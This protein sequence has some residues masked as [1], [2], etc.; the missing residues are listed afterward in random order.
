VEAALLQGD[1]CAALG[2][3]RKAAAAFGRAVDAGSEGPA[4]LRLQGRRAAA[5]MAELTGDARRLGRECRLGL[6]ELAA[7][8]ATVASAEL[9]ARAAGH[10]TV[11]AE[12]GLRAALRSGRPERIWSWLE[13]SRSVV[14]ARSAERPDEHLAPLLAELRS[15]RSRFDELPPDA[16]V[17]RNE[18]LRT[19]TALESRIRARSWTSRSATQRWITP[20]VRALRELR[21]GL[22]ERALL[23]Y[24]E[25][26]GS[27]C[28]VVVT[29]TRIRFAALGRVDEVVGSGRQLGFALRRLSHPR[30]RA[31]V[32]AAFGSANEELRHLAVALLEPL[33]ESFADADEV[34]V[35]PPGDLIGIPW[36]ALEPLADRPVRVVPSALAWWQG[37]DRQPASARAVLVAGPD[38]PAADDEIR[39]IARRYGDAVELSGKRATVEAVQRVAAGARIVHIAGHGRLRSDSPTFSSLQLAD[40]PLTVHDIEGLAEPA[41]HWVLAACDLGNPGAVAGPAL[42][43]VLASLLSGGAGAVVAAVVSVPDLSTRDLMVALHD[44]LAA[45]VAMPESLRRARR[46]L[47]ASDPAGFVAGTAFACYGGG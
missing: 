33:A 10:G 27:L 15:L 5:R 45:G 41:H 14:Y 4:L 25:L 34:I 28:A 6:D 3:T 44:G 12:I 31:S 9:R 11:L 23:Q 8:R 16:G 24:G 43:G 39:Q 2:R 21:C 13:R 20:S 29:R 36:S 30:S 42:E 26:D 46:G 19:V 7:Y 1:V 47:D 32:A 38:L 18:L 22:G 35:A 37:Q 17:E 40:G